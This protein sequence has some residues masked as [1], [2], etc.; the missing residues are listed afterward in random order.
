MLLFTQHSIQ[1]KLLEE[2]QT[3]TTEENTMFRSTEP[4]TDGVDGLVRQSNRTSDILQLKAQQNQ[5]F[6]C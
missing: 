6:I 4:S 5:N 3:T 1:M 2:T